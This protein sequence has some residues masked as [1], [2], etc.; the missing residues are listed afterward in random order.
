[1]QKDVILQRL[2]YLFCH[3]FCVKPSSEE[4][5]FIVL[6]CLLANIYKS[7]VSQP[8]SESSHMRVENIT[9]PNLHK[10]VF[11]IALLRQEKEANELKIS[12]PKDT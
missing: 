12:L 2:I 4:K 7:P 3:F 8:A 6:A 9:K 5:C 10:K 11:V 1:L